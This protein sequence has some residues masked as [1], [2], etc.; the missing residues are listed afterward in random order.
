VV[1]LT[2]DQPPDKGD[3]TTIYAKKNLL[4]KIAMTKILRGLYEINIGRGA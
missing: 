4:F 3:Y 1:V 2:V